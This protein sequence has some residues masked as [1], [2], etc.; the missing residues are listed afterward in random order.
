VNKGKFYPKFHEIKHVI[1]GYMGDWN[2]I[3]HQIFRCEVKFEVIAMLVGKFQS[4]YA[5]GFKTKANFKLIQATT[6]IK[7]QSNFNQACDYFLN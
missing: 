5:G 4:R 7:F 1:P 2:L 6:S 3:W